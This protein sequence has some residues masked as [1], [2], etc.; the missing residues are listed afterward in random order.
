MH[1]PR[2][3]SCSAELKHAMCDLGMSPF[4]NS[5]VRFE[6]S[7]NADEMYP[8]KV[9]VCDECLLAQ[10]EEFQTPEEIF[11]NYPYFSSVSTSWVEH[12]RRYA[13]M[14]IERFG[15]DSSSQVIEIASNDGYLLQHFKARGIPVLG[16]EPAANVARVALEERQ[17]PTLV[18]F[19]GKQTAA[20]L[21]ADLEQALDRIR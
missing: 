2:C 15:L 6:D 16:I 11:G 9:W 10:L 18:R 5:Y 17:I 20:D 4:A 21:V 13:H 12:A 1:K 19:F 7:E 3:R 14:M 8:L